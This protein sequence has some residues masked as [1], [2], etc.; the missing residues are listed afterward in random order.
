MSHRERES[1]RSARGGEPTAP[2]SR[3]R[4]EPRAAR[5]GAR[6]SS[7]RRSA[8]RSARRGAAGSTLGDPSLH[9]PAPCP[10]KPALASL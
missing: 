7:R 4:V 8:G 1:A 9:S 10:E 3:A 5:P 6:G 2:T